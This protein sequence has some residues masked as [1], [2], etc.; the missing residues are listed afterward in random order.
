MERYNNP[1]INNLLTF[2]SQHMGIS[3]LPLCRPTDLMCQL[4]RRAARVGVYT[5]YAQNN[6]VQV[7]AFLPL[8]L[9]TSPL[10]IRPY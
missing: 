4:A 1:P 3:D 8:P 10:N 6:L 9:Y 5:N 7:C 2:G